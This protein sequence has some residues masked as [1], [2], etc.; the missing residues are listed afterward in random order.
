[1]QGNI[2]DQATDVELFERVCAIDA[3][4]GRPAAL[5]ADPDDGVSAVRPTSA[6]RMR[7]S[8]LRS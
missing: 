2:T 1:M 5:A 4:R 7:S 8:G 6:N 3:E